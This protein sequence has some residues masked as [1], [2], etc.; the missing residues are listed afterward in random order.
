MAV[1]V[2]DKTGVQRDW[3]WLQAKYGNVRLYDG[4]HGDS[5]EYYR[6]TELREKEGPATCVV[7]V[8]DEAGKP[9][10]RA[11][12]QGWRDG[13]QL[14]DD[15]D[16]AGGLP[17]GY[18]NRGHAAFPNGN[19]DAGFGWGQ[20]EYYDPTK[21]EGAHYYWVCT[22]ASDVV[23][24]LGMLPLTE[25]LHLDPRFQRSTPDAIDPTPDPP[26]NTALD[27]IA[28]ALESIA[29]RWPFSL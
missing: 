25:H 10:K 18:P 14:P 26:S 21:A 28:A 17:A 2:F 13:P 12:A 15:M 1:K 5:N 11:V 27:R 9:I 29:A 20:G 16:P 7:S 8:F 3:A 19:G 6:L 24:G 22:F 23:T 4:S